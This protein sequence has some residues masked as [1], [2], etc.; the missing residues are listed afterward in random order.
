[1]SHKNINVANTHKCREEQERHP[2]HSQTQKCRENDVSTQKNDTYFDFDTKTCISG[3]LPHPV[4][5]ILITYEKQA[6]KDKSHQNRYIK[7]IYDEQVEKRPKNEENG[8][9]GY[10]CTSRPHDIYVDLALGQFIRV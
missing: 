10:L 3:S 9:V 6:E 2:K 5:D 7:W 8:M 1:M 4:L